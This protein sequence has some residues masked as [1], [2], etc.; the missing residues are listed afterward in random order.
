MLFE[1][2]DDFF[3]ITKQSSVSYCLSTSF[4]QLNSRKMSGPISGKVRNFFDLRKISCSKRVVIYLQV[5]WFNVKK[6][7][8]FITPSTGGEDIFVHQTAI[9][10]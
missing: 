5:K 10:A 9:H 1:N 6:G 7:Y 4:L 2:P 3:M 8:G